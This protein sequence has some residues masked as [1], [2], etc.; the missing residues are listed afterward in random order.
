MSSCSPP[1]CVQCA[2]LGV[3]HHRRWKVPGGGELSRRQ[4]VLFEQRC[5]QVRKCSSAQV[6]RVSWAQVTSVCDFRWQ[7][8][9]GFVPV[10]SLPTFGCRDWEDFS[11]DEGS[12]LIYSSAKSR[13]SKVFKLRNYWVKPSWRDS[14]EVIQWTE[15]PVSWILSSWGEHHLNPAMKTPKIKDP[16]ML[17]GHQVTLSSADEDSA[18][19][20]LCDPQTSEMNHQ[21]TQK[22]KLSSFKSADYT[23]RTSRFTESWTWTYH[24][25]NDT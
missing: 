24:W 2:G 18:S 22:W 5:L 3:F 21:M 16:F 4:L 8:Y 1:P 7:G 13:L 11:T 17:F 19:L 10:H 6:W 23:Q 20:T 14:S 9:E 15:L 12:F 25:D